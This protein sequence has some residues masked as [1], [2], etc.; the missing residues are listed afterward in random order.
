MPVSIIPRSSIKAEHIHNIGIMIYDHQQSERIR[1]QTVSD[2]S[3]TPFLDLR[4]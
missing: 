4:Q 2:P 1:E 3:R